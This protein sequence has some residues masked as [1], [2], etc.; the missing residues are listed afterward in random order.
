MNLVYDSS[1]LIA[2]MEDEPGAEEVERLLSERSNVGFIHAIN[3]CEIF[4]HVRRKHGE[5]ASLAAYAGI[6]KLGLNIREDMDEDMWQ[7]A[8]RIKA[9]YRR[10]SLADCICVS[11]PNR[12]GGEMVTCDRHEIHVLNEAGTCKARFV[13]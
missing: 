13:R 2:Y 8:G 5:E 7:D 1:V 4:Y 11:L 3:L 9:D 6:L 12:I 10:V